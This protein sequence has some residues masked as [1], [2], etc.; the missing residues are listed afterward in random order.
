MS[1]EKPRRLGRGLEALIG[2]NSPN[3]TEFASQPAHQN[4]LRRLALTRIRPNPFQPRREFSETD[5]AEL[6]ASLQA[7]GM[8]QP[9]VV[10]PAG[11]SFELISGERRFRAAVQL[12]WTEIPAL[13]RD[14]DERTMLTLALIENLQRTDLNAVEEARGYQRL[15][16]EFQ[17]THQEISEAVGKER[18]TITN[19]LRVLT[20]PNDVQA[21][22]EQGQLTV[23]HAKALLALA[24]HR[25]IAQLAVEVV[26]E[27]LSVR[28]TERRV[29]TAAG[30]GAGLQ[31]SASSRAP[32]APPTSPANPAPEIRHVRD[33]LRRRFQT[34]I[35]IQIGANSKGE[36]RISFYSAE[37]FNRLIDLLSGPPAVGD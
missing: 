33:V 16:E 37:D 14:A 19:L 29:R 9:V 12:G 30:A 21:L 24:T 27:G 25:Q 26:A 7:S 36:I 34:D 11:E 2:G 3:R 32:E 31:T 10:R 1:P 15:Q 20:L 4:E 17:L 5:L 23:G 13:V 28:A 18:S 8:L 22:L 35:N 6:R